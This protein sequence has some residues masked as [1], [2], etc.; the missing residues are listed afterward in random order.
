[1]QVLLLRRVDA[2][3]GEILR[4]EGDGV[5]ARDDAVLGGF[6]GGS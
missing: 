3:D 4:L 6:A 1:M 5:D 2:Q